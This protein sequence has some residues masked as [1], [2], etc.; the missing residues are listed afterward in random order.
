[1]SKNDKLGSRAGGVPNHGCGSLLA[2]PAGLGV[3]DEDRR[4][5]AGTSGQRNHKERPSL[6]SPFLVVA[7]YFRWKPILAFGHWQ[8]HAPGPAPPGQRRRGRGREHTNRCTRTHMCRSSTAPAPRAQTHGVSITAANPQPLATYSNRARA[9][10]VA[11]AGS[12]VT[13]GDPAMQMPPST[14]QATPP[15]SRVTTTSARQWERSQFM[16]LNKVQGGSEDHG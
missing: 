11:G 8:P 15:Q 2:Q 6:C 4:G 13:E 10:Q 5:G 1:M 12:R 3:G 14:A 9:G 16:K 7:P